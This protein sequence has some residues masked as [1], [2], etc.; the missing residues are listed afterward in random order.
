MN[1]AD[2]VTA[3][4]RA[5]GIPAERRGAGRVRRLS[6]PE[7]E[8]Y[9]WILRRFAEAASPSAEA[10]RAAAADRG[11]DP[12]EAL[13]LLAREDLVHTDGDGRPVVAY[14]FSAHRRGHRVLIDGTHE[15]QAMCALDALGIAPMLGLPIE[16]VSHDPISG[17]EIHVRLADRTVQWRPDAA[18]V[19]AG[20]VGPRSRWSDNSSRS[21]AG[22]VQRSSDLVASQGIAAG[23]PAWTARSRCSHVL[24]SA[25][26]QR[27]PWRRARRVATVVFPDAGGPPIQKT[28]LNE[29]SRDGRHE[30]RLSR[31]R[32]ATRARARTRPGRAPARRARR[33]RARRA[34]R[35]ARAA[36]A[37]PAPRATGS[38]RHA[39]L[40]P[41]RSARRRRRARAAPAARA[42]SR[43]ARGCRR[44]PQGLPGARCRARFPRG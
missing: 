18:V 35:A 37:A 17:G 11:L 31:S 21:A 33:S 5:A 13:A 16:V 42:A 29:R 12:S 27:R 40:P 30:A 9:L 20:S 15:V 3:T 44:A 14:P 2:R 32:A 23:F 26:Y 1:S 10:T 28:C 25:P 8:L 19:L 34:A 4:L 6:G 36:P 39:A 22:N 41:A 43:R 24:V 38:P 7:R